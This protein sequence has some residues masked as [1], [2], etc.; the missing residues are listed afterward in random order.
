VA[1]RQVYKKQLVAASCDEK[2]FMAGPV[3]FNAKNALN[4]V[5]LNKIKKNIFNCILLEKLVLNIIQWLYKLDVDRLMTPHLQNLIAISIL[6]LIIF[7]L[8]LLRC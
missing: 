6:F 8:M 5:R 3:R 4:Q 7:H 2:T 1:Q